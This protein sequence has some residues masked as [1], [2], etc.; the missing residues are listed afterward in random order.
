MQKYGITVTQEEIERVDTVR[1]LWL[2]LNQKV[3]KIV[4][5]LLLI[6]DKFKE[7]LLVNVTQFNNDSE[8]F[9]TDYAEVHCNVC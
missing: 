2:N 8:A 4:S 6:Q 3:A 7:T 1:Y 5:E 9:I